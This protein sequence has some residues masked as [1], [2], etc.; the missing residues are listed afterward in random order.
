MSFNPDFR[1]QSARRKSNTPSLFSLRFP[2]FSHKGNRHSESSSIN[3]STID[4]S[5]T[6]DSPKG[7]NKLNG[8][9]SRTLSKIKSKIKRSPSSKKI[10]SSKESTAFEVN[11]SPTF[12]LVL[13]P[14]SLISVQSLVLDTHHHTSRSHDA[15]PEHK[16][17]K[18]NSNKPQFMVAKP[19][20]A[21]E[22]TPSTDK[23][24]IEK[25]QIA[26]KNFIGLLNQGSTSESNF[27][28]DLFLEEIQSE[29]GILVVV[30]PKTSQKNRDSKSSI[31]KKSISHPEFDFNK[32]PK[33]SLFNS[34][35]VSSNPAIR[36][37]SDFTIEDKSNTHRP[38][39]HTKK[40]V[41]ELSVFQS[42]ATDIIPKKKLARPSTSHQSSIH[43]F[44]PVS[45]KTLTPNKSSDSNS[46]TSPPVK[47]SKKL[48]SIVEPSLNDYLLNSDPKSN[49]DILELPKPSE[50]FPEI[51]E[52]NLHIGDLPA[53]P[54]LS[55]NIPDSP[56]PLIL[57]DSSSINNP[58]SHFMHSCLLQTN[59]NV[60]PSNKKAPSS[61]I[62]PYIPRL[63][64]I[65][66]PGTAPAPA[67]PVAA[68]TPLPQDEGFSHP[69]DSSKVPA[70]PLP[71][72]HLQ[73]H[74]KPGINKQPS[75]D[76]YH[77]ELSIEPNTKTHTSFSE[78]ALRC[79]GSSP[80]R[81]LSNFSPIGFTG[82]D[83]I[84]EEPSDSVEML[85]SKSNSSDIADANFPV[86]PS[87]LPSQYDAVNDILVPELDLDLH[88]NPDLLF[89]FDDDSHVSNADTGNKP[90]ENHCN[91]CNLETDLTVESDSCL[92]SVV[93]NVGL[94][95][96]SEDC[97]F[98]INSLDL[99]ISK[100]Q[101]MYQIPD[102]SLSQT[103]PKQ[104]DSKSLN[105]APTFIYDQNKPKVVTSQL[106]MKP[107]ENINNSID[108]SLFADDSKSPVDSSSDTLSNL[109][110]SQYISLNETESGLDSFAKV[111]EKDSNPDDLRGLSTLKD[112]KSLSKP[113]SLFENNSDPVP[114]KEFIKELGANTPSS[115]SVKP[116]SGQRRNVVLGENVRRIK[117]RMEKM[118]EKSSQI[119]Q[120]RRSRKSTYT[121]FEKNFIMFYRGGSMKVKRQ[122]R[123]LK[124]INNKVK[125]PYPKV[126]QSVQFQSNSN[127]SGN[128]LVGVSNDG[129]C[130]GWGKDKRPQPN[131]TTLCV[132]P[133][134]F[135]GVG[136]YEMFHILSGS[137]L[138]DSCNMLTLSR[139]GI[140]A[141]HPPRPPQ[142]E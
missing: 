118:H 54:N 105:N 75:L 55:S 62:I 83:T 119:K 9:V 121:E 7:K 74:N 60:G 86:P 67:A 32:I 31:P 85:I 47:D 16:K 115:S 117:S 19:S 103:H 99:A 97:R 95:T 131:S 24:S 136:L 88:E 36:K 12:S 73:A 120:K 64:S 52:S 129:E 96:P 138:N 22:N 5:T 43:T 17:S 114:E 40:S 71:I 21:I 111:S 98:D 102:D 68:P 109:S 2:T 92:L 59:N 79:S 66:S 27:G 70:I 34:Y 128:G 140:R 25:V 107:F 44:D 13:D 18:Q 89:Q 61:S 113:I 23:I 77:H 104:A 6:H 69:D 76:S 53:K 41:G 37:N 58:D 126:V 63:S 137:K 56:N 122:S 46:L 28:G 78:N 35:P 57:H 116:V 132:L 87:S 3:S 14:H 49:E 45:S 84:V 80:T 127:S 130:D 51:T 110:T 125:K 106:K 39:I 29:L 42:A 48:Q 15:S 50:D 65:P 112:L 123:D 139:F 91:I 135:S 101:Y 26:D 100:D 141:V 4:S 10:E 90:A 20:T 11:P 8:F 1:P 93:G 81:H 72:I 124:N 133:K 134:K 108:S 142:S 94:P 38:S 82:L 30:N 33:I